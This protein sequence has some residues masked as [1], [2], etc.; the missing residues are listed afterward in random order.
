[1]SAKF[2]AEG[3]I[4]GVY[5]GNDR[6]IG[7]DIEADIATGRVTEVAVGDTSL[8]TDPI[9]RVLHP[10]LTREAPTYDL[11]RVATSSVRGAE[12]V[13]LLERA[14]AQ[15]EAGG[16]A[17][18]VIHNLGFDAEQLPLRALKAYAAAGDPE[19]G[20]QVAAAFR[21]RL[22]DGADT[23]RQAQL[24]DPYSAALEYLRI[25][26]LTRE[27]LLSGSQVAHEAGSDVAAMMRYF[28][29][30][31]ARLAKAR[32]IG[33]GDRLLG[34]GGLHRIHQIG[35]D[36]RSGRVKLLLEELDPLGGQS[37]DQYQVLE[38]ESLDDLALQLRSRGFQPPAVEPEALLTQRKAQA[39]LTLE[40]TFTRADRS[41]LQALRSVVSGAPD[42]G[43][44]RVSKALSILGTT[45]EAFAQAHGTAIAR[46]TVLAAEG[47]EETAARLLRRHW[48]RVSQLMTGMEE[49]EELLVV[50]GQR[51]LRLDF[52]GGGTYDLAG[53]APTLYRQVREKTSFELAQLQR[54]AIE[55]TWHG[56]EAA[57]K[58]ANL[59]TLAEAD[60]QF[61][62]RSQLAQNPNF[63]NL[64]IQEAEAAF[65]RLWA[66]EGLRTKLIEESTGARLLAEYAG[67]EGGFQGLRLASERTVKYANLTAEQVGGLAP[68]TAPARLDLAQAQ[69]TSL[70]N[71]VAAQ[72][73]GADDFIQSTVEM[74]VRNQVSTAKLDEV[75]QL[76]G[77]EQIETRQGA[78]KVANLLETEAARYPHLVAKSKVPRVVPDD[79]TAALPPPELPPIAKAIESGSIPRRQVWRGTAIAAGLVLALGL[80]GQGQKKRGRK[81][82][83]PELF[84]NGPTEAPP[85]VGLANAKIRVRGED[86]RGA[87]PG[88]IK[89]AIRYSDHTW[90]P[91]MRVIDRTAKVDDAYVESLMAQYMGE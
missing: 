85:G 40:S 70:L 57:D 84:I 66:D 6:V 64:D 87:S 5:Y 32:S 61:Q 46:A 90:T 24:G 74:E 71:Q 55:T 23:L 75:L 7:L 36:D 28:E 89:A 45:P 37:L 59:R 16:D 79:F 26:Q 20:A 2:A 80:I 82:E 52:A 88:A 63:S 73:A 86:T 34:E 3:D 53:D 42:L 30:E 31:Q 91:D 43:A 56:R 33:R 15:M 25:P 81:E 27:E 18:Y 38:G 49:A 12:D 67:Q 50:G 19:R 68:R 11:Q 78:H 83:Q 65:Q 72:R 41:D 14:L 77:S 62:I 76:L 51:R 22:A 39:Y 9:R 21:R 4:L 10:E 29:Q 1:V 8:A 17:R 13:P 48:D 69:A 60:A 44:D 47:Q 54:K 35:A 58:L